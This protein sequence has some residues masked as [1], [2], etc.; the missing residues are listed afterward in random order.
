MSSVIEYMVGTITSVST[1]ATA[2]P[3]MT[4]TAIG[5]QKAADSPPVMRVIF[6]KSKLTPVAIGMSPRMVV[7]AVKTTGRNRTSPA[8]TR[9]ERMSWP[10]LRWSSM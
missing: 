5:P 2:S 6:L 1:V 3:K 8:L 7:I 4:A 10:R 9:A